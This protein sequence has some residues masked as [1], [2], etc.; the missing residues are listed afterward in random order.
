MLYI[1]SDLIPIF[2]FGSSII[3]S[4]IIKEKKKIK[5][6]ES[7]SK[8]V[9][10]SFGPTG[11]LFS[12][13][14]GVTKYI[15]DNFNLEG[16]KFAGISG[17]VQ[18]CILLSFNVPVEKG[19]NNWLTPL[20]N[21]LKGNM[22][23]NIFPPLNMMERSKVYLKKCL[24]KKD[25]TELNNKFYASITKVFPYPHNLSISNWD[26]NFD[27]VYAGLQASQY[28]PFLS[29]YPFCKFRDFF[30]I[31]GYIT[32]RFY[33]P[34]KGKWIHVNPFKWTNKNV[35]H[36][37]ISLANVSDIEF[38][39]DQFSLGYIDGEKNHN[40]FVEKG[41]IEKLNKL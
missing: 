11:G 18:S 28:L 21:E 9:G 35:F 19:Y 4:I 25:L 29:G 30:C 26:N 3:I 40:Y 12:Y 8:L 32:S 6:S 23:L 5:K 38:H 14:L 27:D 31:D 39:N 36:G 22:I 34:E 24:S 33:E 1:K 17:G 37:I 10:I 20:V 7:D 16:L 2:L 15:Q 41:L 13:N